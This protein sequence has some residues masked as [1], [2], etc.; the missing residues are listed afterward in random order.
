MIFI[1]DF[2]K[3][4]YKTLR[5]SSFSPQTIK[6]NKKREEGVFIGFRLAWRLSGLVKPSD[7]FQQ[8]LTTHWPIS[9]YTKWLQKV[10]F[11][12]SRRRAGLVMLT[13]LHLATCPRSG[14]CYPDA[15]TERKDERDAQMLWPG[16]QSHAKPPRVHRL[17]RL[18]RLAWDS[19]FPLIL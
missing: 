5:Y 12:K 7:T 8:I 18:W 14:Q 4:F 13:H 6:K 2:Y 11:T 16:R 9:I 10:A 3:N 19:L 15:I 1:K 17:F